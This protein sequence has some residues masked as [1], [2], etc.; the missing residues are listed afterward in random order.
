MTHKYVQVHSCHN[1]DHLPP[2]V[3]RIIILS[4]KCDL[5]FVKKNCPE[6]QV[7]KEVVWN[8]YFQKIIHCTI[9]KYFFWNN[10]LSNEHRATI[11]KNNWIKLSETTICTNV[12]ISQQRW[13]WFHCFQHQPDRGKSITIYKLHGDIT[14]QSASVLEAMPSSS[15]MEIPRTPLLDTWEEPWASCYSR[16]SD[17]LWFYQAR[18]G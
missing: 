18:H 2:Q 17:K 1:I 14:H 16:N 15:T 11:C 12:M 7:A 8:D 6:R 5:E 10:N 3:W 13:K 4:K 9:C